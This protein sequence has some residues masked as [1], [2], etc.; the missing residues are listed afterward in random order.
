M[1]DPT[2]LQNLLTAVKRVAD[3]QAEIKRL[4][5]ENFNLFSILGME[6]A[7]NKTHS[8]FLGELLNPKGSHGMGDVFLQLFLSTIGHKE[9]FTTATAQVVL[10]KY[11]GMRDDKN[12]TGG[13]IDIYVSD[14]LGN[15]LSIENKIKADD[16]LAQIERYANHY[17]SR[18][19]V[20]YLTLDGSEA[21]VESRGELKDGEGYHC[22]S[23]RHHIIEWLSK[24][25]QHAADRPI[26][27]ESLKQYMILIQKLT[28][29]LTEDKMATELHDLIAANYEAAKLV[30]QNVAVVEADRVFAF[31]HLIKEKMEATLK[32]D[33]SAWSVTIDSD[34]FAT[35][36]GI[37]IHNTHWGAIRIDFQGWRRIMNNSCFYGIA[38][39]SSYWDRAIVNARIHAVQT[40]FSGFQTN[41]WC[42]YFKEI[43][44]F[45]NPSER[46][47]LLRSGESEAWATVIAKENTDV[48]LL[49]KDRLKGIEEI[50]LGE[51]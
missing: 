47:R 34:L 33:D 12:K 23:Y 43:L 48:A 37:R 38:A 26:L 41:E 28:G 39:G 6:T 32:V 22:K 25:M 19:T 15:I 20:Y 1:K 35:D 50:A 18:N 44:F 2:T 29:Q 40:D 11:I 17:N 21:S 7:E 49:C 51:V 30:E 27:R 36:A 5:G 46:A 4:K 45:N 3:H 14:S 13:R 10:E 24:C 16:Q 42:P 8:A 31:M 9:A